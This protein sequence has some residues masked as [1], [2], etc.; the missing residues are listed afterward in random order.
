[1]RFI[2]IVFI[3]FNLAS[4]KNESSTKESSENKQKVTSTIN[5]LLSR[6]KPKTQ[7]FSWT[8]NKD[9]IIECEMGTKIYLPKFCLDSSS[10]NINNPVNIIV[11]EYYSVSDFISENLTTLS[12]N[13]I[14]ET[15]GMINI[16]ISQNNKNLIIDSTKEYFILFPKAI[17]NYKEMKTFYGL[18]N[19]EIT[20]EPGELQKP[21]ENEKISYKTKTSCE[22]MLSS[23]TSKIGDEEVKWLILGTNEYAP[24]YIE[25]NLNVSKKMK[26]DFCNLN[27]NPEYEIQYDNKGYAKEIKIKAS[28]GIE[29]DKLIYDFIKSMPPIDMSSMPKK[30]PNQYYTIGFDGWNKTIYDNDAFNKDFKEK[31]SHLKNEVIKKVDRAELNY[32]IISASKLDWINCDRFWNNTDEKINIIVNAEDYDDLNL[33]LV[34]SDIK[35]ILPAYKDNNR[36]FF[37]NVPINK[38]V[39]IIGIAYNDGIPSLSIKTTTTSKDTLL[40]DN[41]KQFSLLE[42]EKKLNSL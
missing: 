6:L 18:V 35:S 31:Y 26:M 39:K 8:S 37:K 3:L 14:L 2:F 13:K 34:F 16:K 23:R 15:G 20:W 30:Y 21:L 24:N 33:N 1:M 32:F 25:Q 5:D 40:L 4:C 41:F 28:A 7:N 11:S 9:T 29:Y 36:Y 12:G 19:N 42:L 27:L 17:D 22:F 10:Y 38:K